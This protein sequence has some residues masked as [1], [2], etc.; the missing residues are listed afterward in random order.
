MTYTLAY[1]NYQMLIEN[2]LG[3]WS[4]E[5]MQATYPLRCIAGQTHSK[6]GAVRTNYNVEQPEAIFGVDRLDG[7]D[8]NARS[9]ISPIIA[10]VTRHDKFPA[11]Q[12]VV[13]QQI[14]TASPIKIMWLT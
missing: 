7:P 5:K 9:K 8:K 4:G 12:F 1:N 13:W 10:Y 6:C 11:G 2:S 14:W 3:T